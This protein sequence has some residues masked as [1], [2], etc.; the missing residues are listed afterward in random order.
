MDAGATLDLNGQ[1]LTAATIRNLQGAGILTSTNVIIVGSGNFAG[2]ITD[3][4][5][6]RAGDGRHPDPD[7]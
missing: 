2:Q 3:T 4:A 7:R 6:L 1:T 5:G